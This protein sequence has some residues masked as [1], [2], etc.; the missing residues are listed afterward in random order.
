MKTASD[1][2]KQIQNKE[3]KEAV[4]DLV[5]RREIG[6][7]QEYTQLASADSRRPVNVP[8]I[9]SYEEGLNLENSNN[10]NKISTGMKTLL[11]K[12]KG[13]DLH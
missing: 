10:Y 6:K 4:M 2:R 9:L 5:K 8:E 11:D 3:H 7:N 12:V 1:V 13:K